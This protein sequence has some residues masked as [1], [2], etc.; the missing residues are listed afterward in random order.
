MNK[1]VLKGRSSVTIYNMIK[2]HTV[3]ELRPFGNRFVI[4]FLQT[5]TRLRPFKIMLIHF[6]GSVFGGLKPSRRLF[7]LLYLFKGLPLCFLKRFV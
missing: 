7:I 1:V 5:V 3:T 4:Y 6:L 2:T